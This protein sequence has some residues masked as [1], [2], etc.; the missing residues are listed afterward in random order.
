M[1]S[2]EARELE[3]MVQE[4][5]GDAAP[6]EGRLAPGVCWELGWGAPSPLD[7]WGRWP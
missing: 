4:G 1:S 7:W 6:V 5:P 3:D 2:R